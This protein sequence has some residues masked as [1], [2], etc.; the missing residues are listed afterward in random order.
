MHGE[1]TYKWLDG[2]L[3]HG[4]Y[5]NDKKHGFGVYVWADGRAYVGNWYDGK[6]DD[7]RVYILPNGTVRRGKWEDGIRQ[8]WVT[9]NDEEGASYKKHLDEALAY[10][11]EIEA[12]RV[13]SEQEFNRLKSE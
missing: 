3:Y 8:N 5:V 9:L 1:G 4:A 13:Q 7:E 10:S 6:Q 2:R 12:M 11:E